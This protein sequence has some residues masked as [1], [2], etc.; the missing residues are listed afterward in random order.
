MKIL[1]VAPQSRDTILG[2][3]GNYCG[4]AFKNLGY[5]I[6]V[7]DF[8][9]S[10]YFRSPIGSIF[11]KVIK[12]VYPYPHR[13]FSFTESLEKEKM[14]QRL[15]ELVKDYKPDVMFV[16]MGDNISS[17]ILKEARQQGVVT[18]NWFHDT[19]LA[20]TRKDF[21]LNMSS[22][23]DYFFII[24]S[25]DVLN[26][27]KIGARCVRTIPL[28]CAPEVYK[29]INLAEEEQKKYRSEV[30]FVGT[31][32][33]NREEVLSHLIDF[34]LGIWGYWIK[35]NPVLAKFYKR[36]HFFAEEAVK[37]YNSSAIIL[38]INQGNENQRFY[39]TPRVFEVPACGAFL[40]T[41]ENPCLSSLYEIGKEIICYKEEKELREL[42]RYY[43]EHPEERKMIAQRGQQ[44][45][46]R[47][48]TYE[49]RIQQIFSIIEK[50]G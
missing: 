28:A 16:L 17:R 22:D 37:I 13:K 20:P 25:G 49:K 24:D 42:I 38:D 48:H 2:A 7:F 23:Y 29:N 35:K 32:K 41:G 46:Y 11:K 8:R 9:R 44:R 15:S 36:K 14:N 21:V 5:Q 30:C 19:V 27:I 50:N 10:Q 45:A 31:L 33:F 4:K 3:I 18:A 1:L 47:D 26:Y 34:D 39:V 6:E 43:L 12:K 40:L